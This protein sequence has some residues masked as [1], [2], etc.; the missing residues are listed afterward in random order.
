MRTVKKIPVPEAKGKVQQINDH[1]QRGGSVFIEV[2]AL[3]D[4]RIYS[5][6]P[7]GKP[8]APAPNPYSQLQVRLKN[9]KRGH[10]FPCI[11]F[12]ENI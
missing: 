10:K 8:T 7:M 1:H 6:S 9:Q 12:T 4:G 11:P 5:A 3:A 2:R